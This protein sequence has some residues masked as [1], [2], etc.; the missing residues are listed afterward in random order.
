MVFPALELLIII[1]YHFTCCS[2]H[3]GP[4]SASSTFAFL[5]SLF[6]IGIEMHADL[7]ELP[8]VIIGTLI[9]VI[10]SLEEVTEVS[11]N[12]VGVIFLLYLFQV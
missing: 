7:L 6:S 12:V 10:A 8:L 9:G 4:G 1:L 2:H 5:F 11:H 3:M